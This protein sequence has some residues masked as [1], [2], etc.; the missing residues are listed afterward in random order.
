[1]ANCTRVGE[2][3]VRNPADISVSHAQPAITRAQKNAL[4]RCAPHLSGRQTR[5]AALLQRQADYRSPASN[6]QHWVL[7]LQ[8]GILVDHVLYKLVKFIA[9]LL[10]ASPFIQKVLESLSDRL[11]AWFL[12][13]EELIAPIFRMEMFDDFL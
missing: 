8:A 11:D 5:C 2:P 12:D 9:Y 1:M 13:L 6:R 3:G 7:F 10:R 4:R